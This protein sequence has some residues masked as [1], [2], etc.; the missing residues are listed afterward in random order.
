MHPQSTPLTIGGVVLKQF[1]GL[2]Y[3]DWYLIPRWLLRSIF[4]RFPE[5]LLRGLL[6]WTSSIC[7]S[8]MYAVKDQMLSDAPTLWCST[9]AICASAGY[10]WSFRRTSVYLCASSLQNLAIL[11]NFYSP[12]SVF[13][14]IL[15]TLFL[16]VWHWLV[17]RA[18]TMIF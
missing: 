13:R 11:Q 3:W 18:E 9:S 15:L 7:G 6:S 12:L 8:I 17:Y 16:M 4:A 5:Q 1:V 14:T 10:T 2:I